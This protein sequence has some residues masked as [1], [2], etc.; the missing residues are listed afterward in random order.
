MSFALTVIVW[1]FII[2]WASFMLAMLVGFLFSVTDDRRH[3]YYAEEGA[4][5][6]CDCWGCTKNREAEYEDDDHWVCEVEPDD[7]RTWNERRMTAEGWG[8]CDT[9]GTTYG[10]A[11]AEDHCVT[12]GECNDHCTCQRMSR[13]DWAEMAGYVADLKSEQTREGRGWHD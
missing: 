3:Q 2:G 1:F 8:L 6:D 9:C 4:W 5:D 7:P 10:L 12:C 11:D 13:D